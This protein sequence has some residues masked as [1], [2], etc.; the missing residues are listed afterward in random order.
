MRAYN[1]SL[2]DTKLIESI[3]VFLFC[4]IEADWCKMSLVSCLLIQQYCISKQLGN[5][6]QQIHL[7]SS[8]SECTEICYTDM[9]VTE[10]VPA[11]WVEG[12]RHKKGLSF[13]KHIEETGSQSNKTFAKFRYKFIVVHK[14]HVLLPMFLFMSL[15]SG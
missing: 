2:L 15:S 1:S 14:K 5:R 9:A 12:R 4:I 6:G 11:L 7:P 3:T 8:G 13:C 10:V